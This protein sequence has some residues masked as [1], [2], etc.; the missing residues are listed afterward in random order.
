MNVEDRPEPI[1]GT[2]SSTSPGTEPSSDV[3]APG[4]PAEPS[5]VDALAVD[6]MA[7]VALQTHRAIV[8][9]VVAGVIA[10]V[11]G[12][13]IGSPLGGIGVCLG[14]G[15]GMLNARALQSSVA[16]R[17]ELLA[18]RPG[19]RTG[20]LTSG[21]TRL[22]GLTIG[23]I[24]LVWLVRPLGFGLVIGLALFQVLMIGFAAVA[25]LKA[26]RA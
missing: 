10:L 17:F 24:L 4:D 5:T 26:V 16:R 1:I 15:V 12:F 7:E 19:R 20:F 3:I 11:V 25:M 22:A 14:L 21:A 9:A 6:N 18:D 23:T 8:P 2:E 13:V